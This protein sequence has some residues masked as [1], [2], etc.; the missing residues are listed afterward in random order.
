MRRLV[1]YTAASLDGKIARGDG[2]VDWLYHDLEFGFAEFFAGI[3]TTISGAQTY[4]EI[5]RNGWDFPY[6]GKTNYVFTRTEGR[7]SK[8][9]V[10][11]VTEDPAAFTAR[12]KHTNGQDIWLVGGGQI[13]SILLNAGLIDRIVLGLHPIVLGEGL[14]LFPSPA[15]QA[16]FRL[17]EQKVCERGLLLLTYDR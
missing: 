5:G 13:N 17:T 1:L 8:D 12:L 10:E 14:P 2:S 16:D 7:A 11:F 4:R 6:T 3:D 15:G 9:P